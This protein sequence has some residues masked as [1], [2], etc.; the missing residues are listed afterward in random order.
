LDI[1][2][3]MDKQQAI[4]TIRGCGLA[5]RADLLIGQLL[6]S[7]R[8]VVRD[9][10]EGSPKDSVVS[11]FG[12][13]PS[14]PPGAAWPVWDRREYL[15]ANIARLEVQFRANPRA[16]GLR[17]IATRMRQ[18]LA[19]GSV[20]LPFLG[21]L[22]L[23]EV[24]AAAALPRWPRDGTLLFF[25]DPSAW[26]FDPLAR[27][28]SRV[29]FFGTHETLAQTTAPKDL[30]EEA[31]FSERRLGFQLEWSLPTRVRTEDGDLSIWGDSEY[32][33]L[34]RQLM[35]S[36]GENEPVHRCGGHPQEIQGDMRL[37]CQLVTNGIY[38]GDSSGYRDPR[39]SLLEDGAADWQLLLQVDSDEKRLGWMWGDAGRVYFWARQQDIAAVDFEGSW[40]V[41]QCY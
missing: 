16:T 13:L 11:H 36:L 23:S 35:G 27:G 22:S 28:H 17:D 24:Y 6:P 32:G 1:H 10:G 38:C 31:R 33:D 15:S 12:G 3:T 41:L 2:I 26:G 8:L 25:C 4:D 29:L 9:G 14:L 20:P 37:E 18:D 19:V 5:G 7:A 34:C 40:C 39:R 21:Q 30:P